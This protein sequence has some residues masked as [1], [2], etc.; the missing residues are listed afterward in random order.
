MDNQLTAQR[1]R[2][3]QQL[4]ESW[5]RR[6]GQ[7]MVQVPPNRSPAAAADGSGMVGRAGQREGEGEVVRRIA[8][9]SAQQFG[10]EGR[11]LPK[12]KKEEEVWHLGTRGSLVLVGV[13]GNAT[14]YCS[15]QCPVKRSTRDNYRH[16]LSDII[17]S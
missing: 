15:S 11:R 14:N 12:G 1:W 4:T 10:E 3:L 6:A 13:P 16:P 2:H 7:E 8:E 17:N 5:R 9:G